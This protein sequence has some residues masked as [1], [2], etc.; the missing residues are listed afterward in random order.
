[1]VQL[2][3]QTTL[4]ENQRQLETG[5]RHA[6]R[7]RADVV[8]FPECATTGYHCD[9]RSIDPA[10]LRAMLREI[11]IVAGRERIHVLLGTPW[12]SGR[13]P[14]NSLVHFNRAG[15]AVYRYDKCHLTAR[16]RTTFAPG[17]HL[18]LFDIDGLPATALICH[19]RRFPELVRLPV[20]AG[21]RIIFHPN[22]GLDRL[23]VSRRKRGG[24]DG[25]A[26][27]AF[28]NAVPYV[29]ANSVGPQGDGLWSA[30]DS[31]ILAADASVLR[32]AGNSR[33][34][35]LVADVDLAQATGVYALEG[36]ATPRFLA[37]LWREMIRRVRRESR[38][39]R[40]PADCL[41]S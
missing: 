8:L 26:A 21:A 9:F 24:R 17:R 5:I 3:F 22:A 29:F 35:L 28:E 13:K 10:R 12:F 2:R 27:R 32:L 11:G 30:G 15:Q 31:K 19:E 1:V 39:G 7:R 23:A 34:E 40:L 16:D 37:P 25:I 33:P 4:E 38:R 36:I 20:M 6:A 14:F 41:A 18:A